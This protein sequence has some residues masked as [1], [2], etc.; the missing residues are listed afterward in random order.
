MI[1]GANPISIG[2][3]MGIVGFFATLLAIMTMHL[4]VKPDVLKAVSAIALAFMS[5]VITETYWQTLPL[6]W[7]FPSIILFMATV[8]EKKKLDVSTLKGCLLGFFVCSL[9]I[10]WETETGFFVAIIWSVYCILRF[11]QVRRFKLRDAIKL[12]FVHVVAFVSE[13]LFAML[14]MNI[15]N[16]RVGGTI[17]KRAFFFPCCRP[18]LGCCRQS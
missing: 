8:Y 15:Y 7:I 13:I 12:V 17:E 5:N 4:I 2:V 18:F 1:F 14:L 11:F 3:M 10:L 9:V 16:V 6:R